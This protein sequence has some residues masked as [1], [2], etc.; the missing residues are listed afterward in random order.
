MFLPVKL[1][2]ICK[3]FCIIIIFP[4]HK[5]AVRTIGHRTETDMGHI[6]VFEEP[7]A[8]ERGK[9]C[10]FFISHINLSMGNKHYQHDDSY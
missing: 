10:L 8:G 9:E 5:F 4:L 6:H 1:I 3:V 7:V 2:E